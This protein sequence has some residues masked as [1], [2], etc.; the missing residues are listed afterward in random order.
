MTYAE[1]TRE[2]IAWVRGTICELLDAAYPM[3]VHQD[4]ILR[5]LSSPQLPIPIAPAKLLKDLEYLRGLDLIERVEIASEI[6]RHRQRLRD[7]PL[8]AGAAP[9]R[10][11]LTAKGKRFVEL[12]MPWDRVESF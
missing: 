10:W 8:S 11:K 6:E 2:A 9:V 3:G 4:A 12:N 7:D 1:E 5:G